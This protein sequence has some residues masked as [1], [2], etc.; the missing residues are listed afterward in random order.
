MV[1]NVILAGRL[2]SQARLCS[3]QNLNRVEGSDDI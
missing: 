3:M 2:S 1:E